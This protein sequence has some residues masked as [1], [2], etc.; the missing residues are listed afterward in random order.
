MRRLLIAGI[1]AIAAAV[2]AAALV[3]LAVGEEARPVVRLAVA[4]AGALGATYALK[5][6]IRRPRPYAALQGVAPRDRGHPNTFDPFS[7]PSSLLSLLLPVTCATPIL[8]LL[9]RL[10]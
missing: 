2:P 6:L 3:A 5:N 1:A 7:F 10:S 8:E 9:L 4:E